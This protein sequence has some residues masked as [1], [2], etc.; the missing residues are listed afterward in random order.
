VASFT[1]AEIAK[2]EGIIDLELEHIYKHVVN[3]MIHIR[4]NVIKIN[5]TDYESILGDYVYKKLDK[6]LV[7]KGDK[8]T[9]EPRG[10][11]VARI[12]VEESMLIV[13][14]SDFKEYLN[15]LKITP[16]EFEDN[17]REN[18]ILIHDKKARLTT[19]W[20]SAVSPVNINA[21]WFKTPIPVEWLNGDPD[22]DS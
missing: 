7:I 4:E 9:L 11:I 8:A 15:L 6:I 13:S 10:P 21:Y 2:D 22:A 19:G 1:G 14:K 3:Q 20:K 12:E 18:E 16:R 5:K 17:M